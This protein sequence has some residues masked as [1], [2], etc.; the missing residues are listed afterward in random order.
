MRRNFCDKEAVANH[1]HSKAPQVLIQVKKTTR[2][3][4]SLSKGA[5]EDVLDTEWLLLG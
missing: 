5:V 4:G 2:I 3:L 1:N